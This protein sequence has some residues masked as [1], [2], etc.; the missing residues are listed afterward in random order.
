MQ[1][2]K[3]YDTVRLDS[4]IIWFMS[5]LLQGSTNYN[6]M[7]IAF[8]I[9]QKTEKNIDVQISFINGS[10]KADNSFSFKKVEGQKNKWKLDRSKHESD[11][12]VYFETDKE[13]IILSASEPN[14]KMF[15]NTKNKSLFFIDKYGKKI[16]DFAN[17]DAFKLYSEYM[18]INFDKFFQELNFFDKMLF[19][20][21]GVKKDVLDAF[22][23]LSDKIFNNK[24]LSNGMFVYTNKPELISEVIQNSKN[25]ENFK[26]NTQEDIKDLSLNKDLMQ[27]LHSL[28]T[29]SRN[30]LLPV[31]TLSN[32]K[33]ANKYNIKKIGKFVSKLNKDDKVNSFKSW[34]I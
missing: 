20:L 24:N 15:Y 10:K 30:I 33:Y 17:Y 18:D 27:K 25:L 11:I 5:I 1:K 8:I 6:G 7:D 23:D 9:S 21:T 34:S 16:F 31:Y 19:N 28:N 26:I 22:N 14:I 29:Q 13:N 4:N 2:D 3:K 32:E 12:D